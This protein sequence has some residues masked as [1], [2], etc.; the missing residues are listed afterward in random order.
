MKKTL[1]QKIL[2]MF[3]L[4][5]LF[6]LV[7]SNCNTK[8]TTET[9]SNASE[10]INDNELETEESQEDKIL[11]YDATTGETTEVDMDAIRETIATN[12]SESISIPTATKSYNPDNESFSNS[13]FNLELTSTSGTYTIVSSSS[14]YSYFPYRATC[15][16]IYDNYGETGIATGF[17]VGPNLLLTSAHCVMNIDDNDATFDGWTAYPG[18][19]EGSSYGGYSCGW[20][21]I[22]YPSEWKENH[23]ISEDWCLCVLEKN[24]GSYCGY[25]GCTSY[26]TPTSL[27]SME[28]KQL[29]YLGIYDSGG[30]QC[31][32]TTDINSVSYVV[33]DLSAGYVYTSAILQKGMYG[34]PMMRT[35]DNSVVAI[36]QG[37]TSN[38]GIGVR[39]N[40]TIIDL[41]NSNI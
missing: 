30:A 40:Q 14:L 22:Y 35:S 32:V 27:L 12:T 17:L 13:F 15:R 21:Y 41:I 7:V 39:I 3:V 4:F 1:I 29:G 34:G 16:I 20:S 36:N 11:M 33:D 6:S 9:I 24:L 18:Y 26:S 25:F 19:Y 5:L 38:A 2:I 23:S 31:Y 37:D 28:V 8:A 10:Y